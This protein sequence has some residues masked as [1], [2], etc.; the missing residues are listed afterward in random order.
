MT[1][2]LIGVLC[3]GA[4]YFIAPHAHADVVDEGVTALGVLAGAM[5]HCDD[6]SRFILNVFAH[7]AAT[8]TFLDALHRDEARYVGDME[9]GKHEFEMLVKRDGFYF[10]CSRVMAMAKKMAAMA[11]MR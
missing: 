9:R 6:D 2:K 10:A 4:L 11:T 7:Y 8:P 1:N 3:V 5:R